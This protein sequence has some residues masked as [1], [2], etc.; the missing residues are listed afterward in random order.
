MNQ[1]L[2]RWL[3]ALSTV[4]ISSTLLTGCIG[5]LTLQEVMKK[6]TEVAKKQTSAAFE[7]KGKHKISMSGMSMEQDLGLKM[8][9]TLKPMSLHMDGSIKLMGKNIDMEAY[10][11]DKN[12]YVKLSGIPNVPKSEQGWM[13]TTDFPEELEFDLNKYQEAR[14]K[15]LDE[16]N[17]AFA[18]FEKNPEVYTMKKEKDVY[19]LTFDS[20]KLKDPE[21]LK[22][23]GKNLV[24]KLVETNPLLTPQ[25][26]SDG[27]KGLDQLWKEQV[28]K[29]FKINNF[30]QV[31]TIDAKT[32]EVKKS[33]LNMKLTVKVEGQE[34]TSELDLKTEYKDA[35]TSPIQIPEDVK[36]NAKDMDKMMPGLLEEATLPAT[37]NKKK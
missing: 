2:K 10:A 17:K 37:D 20:S 27:K 22:E 15:F 32:F 34:A 7:M 30:K 4:A 18:T 11:L 25:Q 31:V 12:T 28:W 36:K 19:L 14:A 9:T 21:K 3:F 6:N 23:T 8:Q 13:K 5:D 33:D 35:P 16:A 29:D 26:K 24:E 1:S